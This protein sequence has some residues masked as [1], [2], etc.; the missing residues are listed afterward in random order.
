[1]SYKGIIAGLLSGFLWGVTGILYANLNE[2]YPVTT[3]ISV[4]LFLLFMVEFTSGLLVGSSI[5]LLYKRTFF[6]SLNKKYILLSMLLGIIGGPVGMLCYLQAITLVGVG[7]AAPISSIY[8]VFGALLSLIFLKEKMAKIGFLGGFITLFCT[9]MLSLDIQSAQ[10]SLL[11][12]ALALICAL[13][14]GSEIVLSSFVMKSMTA[15]NSAK[16]TYFFRQLGA[17][18]GYL[19]LLLSINLDIKNLLTNFTHIKFD[20]F[21]LA[22]VLSSMFSYILYYFAIDKLK[23]IKAMMLNI[24]YG[25]WIVLIG[26]VLGS[27]TVQFTQMLLI[28]GILLGA[29]LVL[30]AKKKSKQI[31]T[32][33]H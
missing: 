16:F 14:W 31:Q 5:F 6:Q 18:L 19:V 22:I 3:V 26:I 10:F 7:Y 17:A 11:G 13:S 20:L 15:T 29:I 21:I 12:I 4:I 2:L 33:T 30:L 8:P 25:V 28:V 24:T 1:M 32:I 27:G 23:P 9:F